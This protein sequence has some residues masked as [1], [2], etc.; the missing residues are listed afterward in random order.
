MEQTYPH[1]SWD[2]DRYLLA[3]LISTKLDFDLL[4]LL[5]GNASFPLGAREN[6]LQCVV[7][8]CH[9]LLKHCESV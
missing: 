6:V 9:S 3:N 7:I 2:F 8:K 5:I 1:N 4:S